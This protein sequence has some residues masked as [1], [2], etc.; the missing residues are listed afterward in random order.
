[1][2]RYEDRQKRFKEGMVIVIPDKKGEERAALITQ[3]GGDGSTSDTSTINYSFIESDGTL[4]VGGHFNGEYAVPDGIK[5]VEFAKV[6]TVVTLPPEWK[7]RAMEYE[8]KKDAADK[9]R[10]NER[11]EWE[12]ET[13]P[14]Y[15]FVQVGRTSGQVALFGSPFTHQHFMTLTIGRAE[16]HRGLAN[17]RHFGGMRG[18]LME[19]HFS[20][21][22][23]ARML[24]SVGMGGGVPCTISRIGGQMMEPCPEQGEVERYH[25]DI[26]R[27]AKQAAKFLDE[28]LELAK[29]LLTDKAPTKAKREELLGKLNSARK[30]LDDSMPFVTRQLRE[31][32]DTVV[33]EAKTEVEAFAQRTLVESGLKALAEVNKGSSAIL[34]MESPKPQ[35]KLIGGEAIQTD[36]KKTT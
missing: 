16:R 7:E 1:M 3:V 29:S 32:M 5:I 6:R 8:R 30:R 26:E 13:H 15:G 22:Q 35:P 11:G 18:D 31:R 25:E 23:W 10:A 2:S 34:E 36:P 33:Q 21:A 28:T 19:V 14:S 20:E 9:K 24:S 17:D 4:D 12:P 27:D